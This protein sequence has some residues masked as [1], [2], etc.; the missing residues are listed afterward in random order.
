MRLR[1]YFLKGYS[2]FLSMVIPITMSCALFAED[3]IYVFLG[4][5]WHEAS[6]I[7]RLLAPTIVVFAL[8]NPLGWLM[9][10]TGRSVRSL[11]VAL[12]IAPIVIFGYVLGLG[13]GPQGVA[14]GFSAA[15][16][17]LAAPAVIWSR[18]GTSIKTRDLV[19]AL[20]PPVLCAVVAAAVAIAMQ[21]FTNSLGP[22]FLRL[23]VENSIAFATYLIM[24]L[25]VMNQK[26][27]YIELLREFKLWPLG[28][29]QKKKE[30]ELV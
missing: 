8:I 29:L 28:W 22:P 4:P 25:F 12:L 13:N 1:S 15:M 2:L 11:K 20:T 5:K 30:I 3:I 14:V 21:G 6:S 26:P 9:L 16:L 24:L 27:L 19:R 23:V 18:Q 7:F 17:V 10:A